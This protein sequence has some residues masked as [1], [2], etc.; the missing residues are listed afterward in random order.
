MI[1]LPDLFGAYQKGRETAI[2]AN[3]NDLK[4]YETVESMR[5]RNDRE[6]LQL[7]ADQAD[8]NIN[9][10]MMQ[11]NGDVSALNA[12]LANKRFYGDSYRALNDA[13]LG[14]AQ[15]KAAT[16][17]AANGQLQTLANRQFGTALNNVDTN[18]YNSGV[19]SF[20]ARARSDALYNNGDAFRKY[21]D[22]TVKYNIDNGQNTITMGKKLMDDRNKIEELDT[23]TKL[24]QALGAEAF[25]KGQNK[26]LTAIE[27]AGAAATTAAGIA[28][29]TLVASNQ[30]A[31][32]Q[33]Q[34]QPNDA[35]KAKLTQLQ[36]Q[37]AE[38]LQ[39][40]QIA[41][42]SGNDALMLSYA[43]QY[44][45]VDAQIVQLG[46]KS[47]LH[48]VEKAV[49]AVRGGTPSTPATPAT[50]TPA[51]QTPAT[52]QPLFAGQP[53]SITPNGTTPYNP[54][55]GDLFINKGLVSPKPSSTPTQANLFKNKVP[56]KPKQMVGPGGY[57]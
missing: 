54:A 31:L 45:N 55:L 33:T 3:W 38:L 41:A 7:L 39:N 26:D 10:S 47:Q 44:G 34:N 18:W 19:N 2:E 25:E 50:Q 15:Y 17:A 42:Q 30:N 9:R 57:W 29:N 32:T 6:A 28:A 52:Q 53:T 14:Q 23:L 43:D 13:L 5:T 35:L 49:A 16:D 46:G 48:L 56:V 24:Y 1:V 27:K 20:D 51:T 22:A 8:Y 37:R 21:V 4:N 12:S 40:I 36:N 11:D